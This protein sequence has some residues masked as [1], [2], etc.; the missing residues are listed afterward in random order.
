MDEYPVDIPPADILRWVRAD[1]ARKTPRLWVRA[2]KAYRSE[3]DLTRQAPRV[4][5]EDD[6]SLATAEAV[7]DVSPARG[8]AAW[9]LRVMAEQE[10][11]L[12]SPAEDSD[13]E[14]ADDLPIDAFEAEFLV[15]GEG[16]VAVVV[17]AEDAGAW[18]AFRRWVALRR[19]GGRQR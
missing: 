6:L 1:A 8:G 9:T 17:L 5:D 3:A 19:A 11:R 16:E 2:S 12:G 18:R 10:V 4:G 15:P 7:M 13:Y 14:D